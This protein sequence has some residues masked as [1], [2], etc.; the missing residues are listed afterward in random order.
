M[1]V[2]RTLMPKDYSP[3]NAGIHTV[4]LNDSNSQML[5]ALAKEQHLQASE[6]IER[7]VVDYLDSNALDYGD[8]SPGNGANP[9]LD[10]KNLSGI[11]NLYR[12]D[13][14]N[15]AIVFTP[16]DERVFFMNA[17]SWSAIERDI[18]TKPYRR[19][20]SLLTSMGASYGRA[21]ALD[22]RSITKD[23]EK[24]TP[25]FVHLGLIAGWGKFSPSGDLEEGSEVIIRVRDCVFCGSRD[26]GA[27]RNDPCYFIAGVARG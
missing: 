26:A 2:V 19:A 6:L 16:T 11:K 13:E 8:L 15:A 22:Y 24:L 5:E 23:S 4:K 3:V 20:A 21:A 25:Y 18:L 7:L 1:F 14:Q 17:H 10:P 12:W 9:R 27:G